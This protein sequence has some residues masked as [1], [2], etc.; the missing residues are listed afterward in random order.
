M[1]AAA[2]LTFL[3]NRTSIA[4]AFPSRPLIGSASYTPSSKGTVLQTNHLP[5]LQRRKDVDII[6]QS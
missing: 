6:I 4:A 2:N 1:P 5:K 3:N